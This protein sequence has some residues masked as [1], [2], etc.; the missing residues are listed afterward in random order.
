M[1]RD[2][3]TRLRIAAYD[4]EDHH[5]H[6]GGRT[7]RKAAAS[8]ES[9]R[10]TGPAILGGVTADED[11][12]RDPMVICHT[13]GNHSFDQRVDRTLRID[14]IAHSIIGGSEGF[15]SWVNGR[16]RRSRWPT[17]EH[18][19][20]PA[21]QRRSIPHRNRRLKR[22]VGKTRLKT[23]SRARSTHRRDYP[24]TTI[25]TSRLRHAPSAAAGLGSLRMNFCR[26]GAACLSIAAATSRT[27]CCRAAARRKKISAAGDRR[28]SWRGARS[29]N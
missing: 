9:F 29:P 1:L 11:R 12:R 22:G 4:D 7:A 15:Q 3:A 27:C 8:R 19:S 14:A 6:P 18:F 21:A 2:Q 26:L 25:S 20:P 5:I 13:M 24:G 23:L 17:L 10:A 28:Q 16:R